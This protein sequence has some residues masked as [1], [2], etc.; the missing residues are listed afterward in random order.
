MI[1]QSKGG[2]SEKI[3]AKT[4]DTSGNELTIEQLDVVNSGAFP[5]VMAQMALSRGSG[6][7]VNLSEITITKLTD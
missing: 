6:G 3:M 1:E 2:R 7:G 4:D 5:I